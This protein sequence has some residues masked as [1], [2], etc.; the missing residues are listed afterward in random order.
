MGDRVEGGSLD[1]GGQLREGGLFGDQLNDRK[2]FREED[3][4]R[5]TRRIVN[6]LPARGDRRQRISVSWRRCPFS[7]GKVRA[8]R[9]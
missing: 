9:F 5:A 1:L 7:S 4:A 3:L 2:I 8:A 6:K